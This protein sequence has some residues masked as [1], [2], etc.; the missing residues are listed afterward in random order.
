[1]FDLCNL[2]VYC[3]LRSVPRLFSIPNDHS[4]TINVSTGLPRLRTSPPSLLLLIWIVIGDS[5]L[6]F[7][8]NDLCTGCIRLLYRTVYVRS[9][10]VR[11]VANIHNPILIKNNSILIVSSDRHLP[12][13]YIQEVKEDG[14]AVSLQLN[15]NPQS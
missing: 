8:S 14:E 3:K 6:D 2:C 4:S 12:D 5:G 9:L 15:T 10:N 13:V 1:M 11:A 7:G